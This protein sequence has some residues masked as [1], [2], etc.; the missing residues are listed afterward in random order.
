MNPA[1]V[2]FEGEQRIAAGDLPEVARAAKQL[3]DRRADAAVLVFNGRTSALVDIDFRGSVD[4]VL[5]RLPKHARP[6]DDEPAPPQDVIAYAAKLM[7]VAPPP[8]LAFDSAELSPMARSF[9]ASNRRIRNIRAK[10]ELGLVFTY[11]TYRA[12]LDALWAA[13]EGR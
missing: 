2:A 1:Y 7:G 6:L 9:Y 12:G 4:D 10:Q 3:L 11:P 13:G 5:A 8:E